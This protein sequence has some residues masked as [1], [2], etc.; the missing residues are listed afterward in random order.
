MAPNRTPNQVLPVDWT[1]VADAFCRA[2]SSDRGS[3]DYRYLANLYAPDDDVVIYDTLPPMGGFLGFTQLRNEIY[4]GLR[5]IA[6]ERTGGVV[7]REM[8]AGQV[9]VTCYPFRLRYGF[10]DGRKV[11]IDARISEVWERRRHRLQRA[12]RPAGGAG[13]QTLR[14]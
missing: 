5:Q 2:W 7:A 3:P 9:V 12:G 14:Q 8:A 1:A 10:A 11:S 6:V 4:P 13:V